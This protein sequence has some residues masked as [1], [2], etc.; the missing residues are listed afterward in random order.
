MARLAGPH[1]CATREFRLPHRTTALLQKRTAPGHVETAFSR[2]HL[3][4]ARKRNPFLQNC[5]P[6]LQKCVL[7]VRT[8]N[9]FLQKCHAIPRARNPIPQN[10]AHL[11][12]TRV[13]VQSKCLESRQNPGWWSAEHGSAGA[14]F[15]AF[16]PS[17]AR[18]SKLTTT[19]ER[20]EQAGRRRSVR[21]GPR[22]DNPFTNF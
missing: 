3:P 17:H 20:P 9:R 11:L 1:C 4:C 15:V 13:P 6:L 12:D 8:R 21:A 2:K 19:K 7:I 16:V 18:C 5:R 14:G 22:L 10:S